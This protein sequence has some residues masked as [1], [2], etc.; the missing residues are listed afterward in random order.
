M[1][2]MAKE[3]KVIFGGNENILKNVVRIAQLC[4]YTISHECAQFKWVKY[5]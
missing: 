1:Q 2:V 3:S 4:E 5:M